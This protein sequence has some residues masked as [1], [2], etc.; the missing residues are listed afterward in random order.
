[1]KDMEKTIKIIFKSGKKNTT[2]RELCNSDAV[3]AEIRKQYKEAKNYSGY[4]FCPDD[5]DMVLLADYGILNYERQC[6]LDNVI[7]PE[8]MT[9][10]KAINKIRKTK[11]IR[12][13]F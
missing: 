7:L 13:R 6:G 5:A 9:A 8:G 11:E 3:H 12:N 2:M 4:F 1:M 10:R